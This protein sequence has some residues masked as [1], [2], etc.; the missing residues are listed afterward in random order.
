MKNPYQKS[1]DNQK[2]RFVD[3]VTKLAAE[4]F[5]TVLDEVVQGNFQVVN[6]GTAGQLILPVGN[7]PD[8]LAAGVFRALHDTIHPN[9]RIIDLSGSYGRSD[10]NWR[11]T[12]KVGEF[13]STPPDVD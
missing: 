11:V 6:N 10:G 12:F 5:Q 9:V 4:L 2:S 8:D 13:G 1:W 3:H 7:I